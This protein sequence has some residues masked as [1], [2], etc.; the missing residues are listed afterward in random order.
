ML[1]GD[2]VGYFTWWDKFNHFIAF[3]VASFY[4]FL[5][6]KNNK[7]V[8]IGMIAFGLFIEIAQSFTPLREASLWDVFADI[9]GTFVAYAVYLVIINRTKTT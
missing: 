2:E 5:I 9:I 3:F 7:Y 4:Y 6:S 1:K 8:L